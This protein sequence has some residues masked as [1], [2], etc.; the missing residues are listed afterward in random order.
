[1]SVHQLCALRTHLAGACWRGG[2]HAADSA[3]QGQGPTGAHYSTGS[4]RSSLRADTCASRGEQHT[5]QVRTCVCVCVFVSWSCIS[6]S[7]SI[8]W[9]HTLT[10]D[11]RAIP[12]LGRPRT[13]FTITLRLLLTSHCR[14]NQAAASLT[15]FTG[16]GAG[17]AG[18]ATPTGQSDKPPE[19]STAGGS[20]FGLNKWVEERKQ[21]AQDSKTLKGVEAQLMVAKTEVRVRMQR[22]PHHATVPTFALGVPV[23]FLIPAALTLP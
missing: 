22:T 3:G 18:Q 9:P 23:L 16:E 6:A 14:L 17:K 12:C 1:M 15:H 10:H 2:G 21:A 13:P 7:H 19:G 20:G 4:G 5:R 8:R 11:A